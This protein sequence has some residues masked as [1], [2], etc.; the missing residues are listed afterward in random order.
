MARWLVKSDPESYAYD[1]LAR[2]GST[3]WSGVHNALAL[4]HLRGMRPGDGILFYHSG[5]ERAV[6]GLARVTSLPRPD[7]RDDRGSW[8]VDIAAVRRLRSSIS[9]AELRPDRSLRR[10]P[11]IT[12]SRLSVMPVRDEEWRAILAHEVAPA[13]GVTASPTARARTAGP[14]VRA[15]GA[16][17]RR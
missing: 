15:S 1:D 11:L 4:R 8:L 5:A 13:R 3:D 2:D 6:V 10:L 17:R 7:L 16:R 12:F 9:L 14:R